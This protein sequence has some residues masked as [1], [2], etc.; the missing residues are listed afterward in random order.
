[1]LFHLIDGLKNGFPTPPILFCEII[2]LQKPNNKG[3]E[4]GETDGHQK[5]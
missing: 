1:M 2:R 4:K 3:S 5:E